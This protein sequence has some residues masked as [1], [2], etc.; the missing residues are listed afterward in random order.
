MKVRELKQR[1]QLQEWTS[2]IK[3]REESGL[4]VKQWCEENGIKVK[5]Y[6]NRLRRVR[7]EV[8]ETMR[9]SEHTELAGISSDAVRGISAQTEMPVFA[10]ISM[11]QFKSAAITVWIGGYAVD[12]QNG[13]EDTIVEQA[14]RV[15]SRL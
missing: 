12:I 4:S 2:H 6:Y 1:M 8:L 14:L 9:S 3:S 10:A 15:V 7:E 11:P 13:A 5:T